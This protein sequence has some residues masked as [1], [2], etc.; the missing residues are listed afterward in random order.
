MGPADRR[1]P[2]IYTMARHPGGLAEA[3][4]EARGAKAA[5]TA[6]EAADDDEDDSAIPT[7]PGFGLPAGVPERAAVPV[8]EPLLEV[9]D[10]T[11]ALRRA[12]GGRR[13]VD[14]GARGAHRR[15]D[16]PERR[17]QVHAVQRRLRLRAPGVR[18]RSRSAASDIE[19]LPPHARAAAR[20]RPHVPA[21]RAGPQPVGHGEPAARPAPVARPTTSVAALATSAC[22]ADVR[23]GAASAAAATSSRPSASSATPT[24]R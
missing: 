21:H 22:G 20:H 14:H 24:R 3:I 5:R 4:A 12:G 15:A 23:G 13:R 6:R 8:G 9:R 19:H 7:L 10:V 1:G 18:A 17:G 2:L 11:R 16:R